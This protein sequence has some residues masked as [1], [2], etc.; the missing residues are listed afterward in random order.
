ML[1]AGD[2]FHQSGRCDERQPVENPLARYTA[3][4]AVSIEVRLGD[5]IS[6]EFQYQ[7]GTANIPGGITAAGIGPI[8]HH[9]L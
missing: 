7:V 9:G 3:N 6:M 2:V 1:L 4:P 8:D 5:F